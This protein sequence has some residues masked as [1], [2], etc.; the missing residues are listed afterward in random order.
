[1]IRINICKQSKRTLKQSNFGIM[2][3][4][5]ADILRFLQAFKSIVADGRGL[6][7][8]PRMV[9]R[10][11][12]INLGLTESIRK[13]IIL[14]LSAEDYCG[15][16]EPDNERPGDVW[17]FGARVGEKEVYIKLK[18]GKVDDVQIA[19]C[20]SFHEAEFQLRYPHRRTTTE[21]SN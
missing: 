21:G 19:K 17:I 9:N 18:I 20:L 1:M 5:R 12:L 4:N 16:P 10:N 14:A 7:V 8:V 6:D 15:G 2:A 13:R 3:A 11:A